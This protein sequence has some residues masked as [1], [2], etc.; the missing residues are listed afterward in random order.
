MSFDWK[1]LGSRILGAIV[2]GAMAGL[3]AYAANPAIGVKGAAAAG[4][5]TALGMTGYAATH[6]TTT[7][8]AAGPA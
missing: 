1:A 8:T 6:T 2:G 3:G 4:G 5:V 7:A